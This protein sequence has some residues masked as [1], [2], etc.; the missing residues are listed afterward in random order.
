MEGY[1]LPVTAKLVAL[2]EITS[3][4]FITNLGV[5]CLRFDLGP[6][7]NGDV[8]L[9][10]LDGSWQAEAIGATRARQHSR[11]IEVE[12]TVP[13]VNAKSMEWKMTDLADVGC[14]V[15]D[16]KG[17]W[18]VAKHYDQMA[19]KL[20]V[21]VVTGARAWPGVDHASVITSWVIEASV[22]DLKTFEIGAHTV[23][24][25]IPSEV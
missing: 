23:P 19:E 14:L 7:A 15:L 13:H 1:V 21:N 16:E 20:L 8:G 10:R 24:P 18:I 9:V 6:G 22:G 11:Y 3:R 2:A 25:L 5:L 17:I 4:F 12:G